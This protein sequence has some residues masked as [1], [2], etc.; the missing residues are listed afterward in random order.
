[1]AALR[2]GIP[3]PGNRKVRRSRLNVQPARCKQ[4][5]ATPRLFHD[6]SSFRIHENFFSLKKCL[7]DRTKARHRIFTKQ[8]VARFVKKQDSAVDPSTAWQERLLAQ[9]VERFQAA[10]GLAAELLPDPYGAAARGPGRLAITTTEGLPPRIYRP[11]VR[12]VEQAE[13]LGALKAEISACG[14]PALLV[15]ESVK[16]GLARQCRELELPFLDGQGNAF[17]KEKDLLIV[18]CGQRRAAARERGAR[19]AASG[20]A[21]LAPGARLVFAV[22]STPPLI[23]GTSKTLQ[24]ASGVA[25][26]SVPGVLGDL[27]Q[28]GLV[29]RLGWGKGCAVPNWG[30]LLDRWAADYPRILRPKLRSLHFRSPGQGLWWKQVD[31][32]V[33][34]GQWGG[35]VAASQLGSVLVPEQSVIYLQPEAM[36]LGLAQLVKTQGLRSDPEGDVAVVEAFWNNE[37]LGLS[38]ATVPIPLV[39]ADLLASLDGRNIEAARE[40]REIWLRGV[41]S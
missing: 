14:E 32:Q 16:D 3:Q 22:L 33:F 37:R 31:P 5:P 6:P 35:E 39:I 41:E 23:T 21:A 8:T 27:E 40:L 29:R 7:L 4:D 13:A 30:L 20:K 17:L 19:P 2:P 36:R 11:L 9:A 34:G 12:K 18:V 28:Q 1:M 15:A 25:M 38:S 24:A 26:G 10:T